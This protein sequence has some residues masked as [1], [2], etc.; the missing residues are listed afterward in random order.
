MARK[1]KKTD[2]LWVI[3]TSMLKG[4]LSETLPTVISELG[5][6]CLTI[7]GKVDEESLRSSPIGWVDEGYGPIVAYGS[8]NFI[9]I[10]HFNFPWYPGSYPEDEMTMAKRLDYSYY[11]TLIQSD[12][13]LN[14]EFVYVSVDKLIENPSKF[15][16]LFQ[17]KQLFI[18]DNCGFKRFTAKLCK[19][20]EVEHLLTYSLGSKELDKRDLVILSRPK[21]ILGEHRF[22]IVNRKVVTQ[23]TYKWKD[24]VDVRRD[25]PQVALNFARQ[26]AKDLAD[27]QGCYTLDV[28]TTGDSLRNCVPKVLELN[29][30]SCAGFYA[31][32][33][34]KLVEAVSIQAAKDYYANCF[35]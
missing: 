20:D 14:D 25:V 3:E 4:T 28:A 34:E 30:F 21:E 15:F 19:E 5:Y 16:K 12:K 27:F 29:S 8:H 10:I 31:C 18:K 17:E 11:S 26:V 1:F 9:K 22:F 2:V 6:Q 35:Y 23:S 13:L 7:D 32:D 24:A 33:P